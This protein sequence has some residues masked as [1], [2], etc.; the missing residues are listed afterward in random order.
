MFLGAYRVIS[1]C[2]PD[3]YRALFEDSRIFRAYRDLFRGLKEIP[4]C[5]MTS[6]LRLLR[7]C[8]L[9]SALSCLL[10]IFTFTTAH[11][12]Y[13]PPSRSWVNYGV[14]S[15]KLIWAPCAHACPPPPAFG[16]IYEGR[17]WSA[18]I[19]DISLR[20]SAVNGSENSLSLAIFNI[21][22]CR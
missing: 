2:L 17:Y 1:R 4:R 7:S 10:Q 16:P 22:H 19:D 18:K 5:L 12:L 21:F 13:F 11:S 8:H 6:L 14:R 15:P 9:L 3:T 20:P